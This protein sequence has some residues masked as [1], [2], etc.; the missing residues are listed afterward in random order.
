[1]EIFRRIQREIYTEPHKRGVRANYSKLA[2]KKPLSKAQEQKI[3]D[4]W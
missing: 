2:N 3:L 4:Y 1:M